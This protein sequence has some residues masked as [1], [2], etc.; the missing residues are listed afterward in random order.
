ML[1]LNGHGRAELTVSLQMAVNTF[2]KTS[3]MQKVIA[4]DAGFSKCCNQAY[5]WKVE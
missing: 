5:S 1:R 4:K 3:K 2:H